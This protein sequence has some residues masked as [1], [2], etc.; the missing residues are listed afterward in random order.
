MQATTLQ[1]NR[2]GRPP[3]LTTTRVN[4]TAEEWLLLSETTFDLMADDPMLSVVQGCNKAQELL[5]EQQK[6]NDFRV[7]DISAAGNIPQ[8]VEYVRA[9]M[10]QSVNDRSEVERLRGKLKEQPTEAEILGSLPTDE[11]LRLF[12]K[13][14][15]DNLSPSEV[16]NGFTDVELL[17]GIPLGYLCGYATKRFV[18][19]LD[20]REIIVTHRILNEAKARVA[21]NGQQNGHHAF[22]ADQRL[23]RIAIVG[24]QSAQFSRLEDYFDKQLKLIW[25]D[26]MK[27]ER[28]PEAIDGIVV[29]SNFT[30][31][32]QK[33]LIKDH[34]VAI[35]LKPDHRIEHLGGFNA[36]LEVIETTFC[37]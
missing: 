2:I 5:V 3:G 22:S 37:V 23:Q 26:K 8:I 18:D 28:I 34:C 1:R 33:K 7:R 12:G 19:A 6:W 32:V 16:L 10:K 14:V 31:R 15:L 27:L 11:V 35:H 29:W 17:D 4:W 30:S 13:T 9:R 21:A 25:L 36:L 24:A 20:K